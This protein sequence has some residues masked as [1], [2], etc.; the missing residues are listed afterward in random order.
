MEAGAVSVPMAEE[1]DAV[2]SK[3]I[4]RLERMTA[5]LWRQVTRSGGAYIPP[6]RMLTAQES[7]ALPDKNS[8]AFQ[9]L[10]WDALRRSLNGLVNKVNN[11]NIGEIVREL[12]GEN[13]V[14]GRGLL[15]RCMMKAQSASIIYTPVYA[16]VVAVLNT[17]FPLLGEL[18]ITRLVATFRK[19]Y[20]R[21]DKT[22]C[23]AM[24]TFVAHLVNQHVV[25]DICVLQILM[26][27]L[28]RPTDDSVE[29]AVGLMKEVGAALTELSPKPTNAVFERF[30]AV[31]YEG[32]IDKRVQ[33]MIE[34]L[35]QVRKEKFKDNPAIPPE[36]DLVEEDDQVTHYIMLDDELDSQDS[37]NIFQYD[38]EYVQHEDEY[39]QIKLEILGDDEEGADDDAAAEEP[40]EPQQAIHDKTDA[41]VINF[42]KTAYL[43]IMSSL[44][45]EECGHKLLKVNIPEGFEIELCHMIVECSSNERNYLKFYGLLAERFCKIDEL[46]RMNFERCFAE[47][48]STAHRMETNRI[49]NVSKVF[50]HLF[51]TD[52]ITWAVLE[53]VHLTEAD[54]TSAGRIFLKFLFQD[55]AEFYGI[56]RLAARFQEADLQPYFEGI[57]PTQDVAH[58]RFCINFFTAIGLA[59][60]TDDMRDRLKVLQPSLL[61]PS[62]HAAMANADRHYN[63]AEED[64]HSDQGRSPPTMERRHDHRRRLSPSPPRRS[65]SRSA[66]RP[67]HGPR[68]RSRSREQAGRSRGRHYQDVD[69]RGAS[70][71]HYRRRD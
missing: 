3:R 68:S 24:A 44:D 25:H 29:I 62:L 12:I 28:E 8:E 56:P 52:A 65:R 32:E 59:G 20:R 48:Y 30:R 21:N 41:D 47:V 1:M 17:K 7:A 45:F 27:L 26:L 34:V 67:G 38:A 15:V 43:T 51:E 16:A 18:L 10:S 33:Y 23:I 57:F 36:L 22:Q 69:P 60:L 53:C 35:F 55:L 5:D 58:L 19:A 39:E 63:L 66:S 14:R 50:G 37:L 31:L 49:R 42:R 11:S 54:T 6:K 13:L 4:R 40:A 61:A 46:W 70:R 71:E 2:S 64:E 9:R